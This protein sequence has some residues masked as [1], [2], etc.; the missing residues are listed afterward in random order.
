VACGLGSRLLPYGPPG[1]RQVLDDRVCRLGPD[2]RALIGCTQAAVDSA[3]LA[4]RR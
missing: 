4:H 2:L 1:A 3:V